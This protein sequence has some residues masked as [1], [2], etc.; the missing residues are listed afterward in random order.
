MPP[1]GAGASRSRAWLRAIETGWLVLAA[2]LPLCFSPW[3]GNA[4]ELPKVAFLWAAVAVMTAAW[5]ADGRAQAPTPSSAGLG[6]RRRPW[7]PAALL[8]LASLLLATSTSV[9]P[10]ISAQGSYGRM[11]GSLTLVCGVLLFLLVGTH[12]RRPAQVRRLLAAVAWGSA[13]VVA[14]GLLQAAGLDPLAWQVEG[15]PAIST[16]GRSNFL[17]AYLVLVMPLTLC[18]ARL[19]SGQVRRV[20]YGVLLVAQL[21]CLLSTAVRAALLGMAA[22]IFVLVLAAAWNRSWRRWAVAGLSA[23]AAMLAAGLIYT[24]LIPGLTGSMGARQLIWRATGRLIVTRPAVGCGPETFEQ[25]FTGVYPSELVYQ[26][27]RAVVVDRAHNLILDTWVSTGAVGLLSLCLLMGAALATGVRA[28]ARV[29]DPEARFVLAGALAAIA[30]HLVETQFSFQVTTTAVLLWLSLGIVVGPWRSG[31]GSPTPA[32]AS[33]GWSMWLRRA[34]ALVVV[35]TVI[36][37]S[38]GVLVADAYAGVGNHAS[39]GLAD[40]TAA[41]Q[42]AASLWPW[43]PEY[44]LSLNWLHRLQAQGSKEPAASFKAAET[45]L[46][47]ARELTPGDYL[48]WAGYAELYTQW[49]QAG[50][51]T[52]YAQAEEAYRRATALYPQNAMLYTGWGLLA[53]AQNHPEEA[54]ALFRQATELDRTDGWAFMYLGNVLLAQ[55]DL[56]G[57]EE[58]YYQALHWVP[59]LAGALEGLGQVYHRRGL[60]ETA[61]QFIERARQLDPGNPKLYL[62]AASWYWELGDRALACQMTAQGL[63]LE[64][65]HPGLLEFQG[66]CRQ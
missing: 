18:S 50:D 46:D 20:G 12:L 45:A 19:A 44:Q 31:R 2:G 63:A 3:G 21:A 29:R 59:G 25:V 34:M 10:L 14:Y 24:Y 66:Q 56:V 30:G 37:V 8:Y 5:L 7:F 43:Q 6:W 60:T 4:F 61:L 39:V 64:P 15:S 16:L 1:T 33:A 40:R 57:A 55:G 32:S 9:N 11:Q 47:A 36:P 26:Q 54:M 52:R 38:A 27:G 53:N 35:V 65:G 13:P 42:R 17:G 23:G 41:T 51:E 28:C 58:A 62:E 22:V 49:G 48:V